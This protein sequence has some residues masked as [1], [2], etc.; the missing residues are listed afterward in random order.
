M[1]VQVGRL[2]LMHRGPISTSPV[3]IKYPHS[4]GHR[5]VLQRQ[6]I[7]A[8]LG[9]TYAPLAAGK[10]IEVRPDPTSS[11]FMMDGY[12]L[13]VQIQSLWTAVMAMEKKSSRLDEMSLERHGEDSGSRLRAR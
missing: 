4:G 7:A 9:L 10:V 8:T 12:I 5:I 13:T 2:R 6:P 3:S 1:R 11:V